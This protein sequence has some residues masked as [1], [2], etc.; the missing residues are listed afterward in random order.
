MPVQT[1]MLETLQDALRTS[2][3]SLLIGL[4]KYI[5]LIIL[6]L[7]VFIIGWIIAGLVG[8]LV[9]DILKRVRFNQIFER[10]GWK[11]ALERTGT[12]VDP[13]G[14]VGAIFK[15]TLAIVFLLVA[16]DILELNTFASFLRDVLGYIPNVIVAVLIIVV[17]VIIAD[18]AEKLVR[19]AV[20][21]VQVGYG[22]LASM[23]VKWFIW[24]FA[25][26]SALLQLNIAV[27]PIQVLIQTFVTALGYG[28]ALAFAIAFGLGGRDI[29][30]DALRQLRDKFKS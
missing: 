29:A 1:T 16:V 28:L 14:F 10:K 19:A 23:I 18:I 11:E 27:L 24:L 12:K 7:V 13:A 9:T 20:E 6:A 21:S 8:K 17:A 2:F 15:W 5:P 3:T 30:A 4:G 22:H 26:F 25:I